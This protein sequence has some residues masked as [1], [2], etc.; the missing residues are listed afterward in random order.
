MKT[1]RTLVLGFALATTTIACAQNLA[2]QSGITTSGRE[3][4]RATLRNL[5][6]VEVNY[7]VDLNSNIPMVVES[8]LG[9][10]T[11]MRIAYPDKDF[12]KIQEK[13]YDLAS[14]GATRSIRHKAFMA[15]QVYA[16]PLAYKEVIADQ[17]VSG[18]GLLEVLAE[19]QKP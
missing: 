19:R 15:M 5:R 8:A 6:A 7:L 10:V 9:H 17:Q 14:R 4:C 2:T 12:R 11:L 18:D 3:G 16:D 1:C 13:L